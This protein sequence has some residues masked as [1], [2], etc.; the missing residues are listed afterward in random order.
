VWLWA[1][2]GIVAMFALRRIRRPADRERQTLMQGC[3]IIEIMII[4]MR[5]H[6]SRAEVDAVCARIEDSAYKIHR[7]K[8]R[9]AW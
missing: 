8:A 9:N 7:L 4:S 2:L 6:A 1:V 5:M 3:A